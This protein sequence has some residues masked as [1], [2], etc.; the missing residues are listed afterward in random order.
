MFTYDS[1]KLIRGDVGPGMI[2]SRC[3]HAQAKSKTPPGLELLCGS[4]RSSKLWIK[5]RRVN[6]SAEI[7]ELTD[8]YLLFELRIMS[9]RIERCLYKKNL[10]ECVILSENSLLDVPFN[11]LRSDKSFAPPYTFVGG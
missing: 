5:C 9:F 3:V 7:N 10:I 6:D 1:S 4:S 11:I 2:S 8:E